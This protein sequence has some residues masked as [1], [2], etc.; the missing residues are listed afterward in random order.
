MTTDQVNTQKNR[1]KLPSNLPILRLGV[2]SVKSRGMLILKN[3]DSRQSEALKSPISKPTSDTR[4]RLGSEKGNIDTSSNK[5]NNFVRHGPNDS[6]TTTPGVEG[7]F[8]LDLQS[9][10]YDILDQ[11]LPKLGARRVSN[12]KASK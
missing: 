11:N 7:Q 2:P 4:N 10:P 5:G 1:M 3:V 9:G 8:F 6:R 12:K